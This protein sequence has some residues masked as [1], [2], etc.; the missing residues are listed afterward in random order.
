MAYTTA[1]PSS[2]ATL[3]TDLRI[4][5]SLI[6]HKQLWFSSLFLHVPN[7]CTHCLPKSIAAEYDTR[8]VVVIMT[9]IFHHLFQQRFFTFHRPQEREV[10]F[11]YHCIFSPEYYSELILNKK[12]Y[13]TLFFVKSSHLLGRSHCKLTKGY[14]VGKAKQNMVHSTGTLPNMNNKSLQTQK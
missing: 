11:Y 13:F 1:L 9:L 6:C 4:S 14:R 3:L 5:V 2:L 12:Y 10:F 8:R 7:C